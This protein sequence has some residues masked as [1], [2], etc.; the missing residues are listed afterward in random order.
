M[1]CHPVFILIYLISL[2]IFLFHICPSSYIH[3]FLFVL[4]LAVYFYVYIYLSIC[5]CLSSFPPMSISFY[6]RTYWFLFHQFINIYFPIYVRSFRLSIPLC[7]S[8][9]PYACF[10]LPFCLVSVPWYWNRQYRE[11][12]RVFG[13]VTECRWSRV[14]AGELFLWTWFSGRREV[15]W[16][17]L[18]ERWK[19]QSSG[20]VGKWEERIHIERSER[21]GVWGTKV[22]VS[23][24]SK[25]RIHRHFAAT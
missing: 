22:M 2:H 10:S 15:E 1:C 25:N 19:C 24:R 20:D 12:Y 23:V 8:I 7:P 17:Q 3:L 14:D 6:E 13:S 4:Q 16:I 5:I 18:K 9:T 11:S 21:K